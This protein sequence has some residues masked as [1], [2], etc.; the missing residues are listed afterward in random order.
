MSGHETKIRVQYYETDSMG[1]VHHSNYIRYFETARTEML[2]D[3]GY[4]YDD[5]EKAGVWMPVLS[6]SVEYK[7]PAVYDEVISVFCSVEKLGGASVNLAYEVRGADGRLCA[8]GRSSHGFTDPNLKPLRMKKQIPELYEFFRGME[9]ES[10]RRE[11][12]DSNEG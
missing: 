12:E 10:S 1:I 11:C 2:R 8:M 3:S 5:M 9:I 7:M 4:A 6:V